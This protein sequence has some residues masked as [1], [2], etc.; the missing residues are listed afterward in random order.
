MTRERAIQN[1]IRNALA[2]R[3]LIFR[4]N[5]GSAWQGEAERVNRSGQRFV[6]AGSIILRNPRPFDTGLPA[7][8]SDLF[9]LV[10]VVVGPHLYGETIARFV[11]LEV[12]APDGRV[13]KQQAQ[14]LAAV[15]ANGALAGVARSP[16]D[17]LRIIGGGAP[18]SYRGR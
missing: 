16:A 10:P 9:G 11:A 1:E 6:E 8:F 13:R 17:A 3:G 4:A 2:G 12:K 18:D 15:T 14:F 5:V 7:G